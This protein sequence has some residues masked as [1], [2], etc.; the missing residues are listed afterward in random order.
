MQPFPH[1]YEAAA[2]GGPTGRTAVRSDGLP[3]LDTDSPMEFDGPGDRWSPEAM[4]AAAVADCLVLT[5]RAVARASHFEWTSLECRAVGT[6]DRVDGITRF[7]EMQIDARLRVP[8]GAD[9]AKA[10][11]LLEKSEKI[12]LVTNSL[13]ARRQLR[14]EVM[15]G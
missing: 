4:M 10:R 13:T 14:A 1:E 9:T 8:A 6:L 15:V 5:F 11:L 3:E 12:C 2:S 7:T